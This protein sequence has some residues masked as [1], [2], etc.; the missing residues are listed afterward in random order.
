MVEKWV[1]E[2]ALLE[3]KVLEFYGY[4]MQVEEDE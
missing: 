1:V 3:T 4:I 2:V